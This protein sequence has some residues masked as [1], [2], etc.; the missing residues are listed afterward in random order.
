MENIL[1]KIDG[2]LARAFFE[3]S[4]SSLKKGGRNQ[5]KKK[6]MK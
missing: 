1:A 3:A 5:A 6:E 2:G 4:E